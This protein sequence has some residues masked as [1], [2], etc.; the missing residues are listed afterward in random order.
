MTGGST[1]PEGIAEMLGRGRGDGNMLFGR[2]AVLTAGR[3]A[4]SLPPQPGHERPD[5]GGFW[6]S[7]RGSDAAPRLRAGPGTHVGMGD[8][9]GGWQNSPVCGGMEEL[10]VTGGWAVGSGMPG[11]I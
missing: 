4:K 5:Y 7:E 8:E 6:G 10:W 9:H 11:R 2:M 3:V 1:S